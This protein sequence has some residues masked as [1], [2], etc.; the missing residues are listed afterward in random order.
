MFIGFNKVRRRIFVFHAPCPSAIKNDIIGFLTY[1][2]NLVDDIGL[3]RRKKK[4][5][6][7]IPC[8]VALS[9][10]LYRI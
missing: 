6:G 2:S 1:L 5:F 7:I 9:F 8:L 4:N 3:Y 10:S